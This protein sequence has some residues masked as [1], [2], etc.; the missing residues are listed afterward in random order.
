MTRHANRIPV[1]LRGLE[2]WVCWRYEQRRN[3]DGTSGKPT[4]VPYRAGGAGKAS[5]T[6]RATWS[7]YDAAVEAAASRGLDGIGFVFTDGDTFAGVDFD[8]CV[9]EGQVAAH[10]AVLI[11]QLD[12]Y[13]EISPSETG[14]HVIVKAAVNGG[15]KKIEGKDTPWGG[16]FENYDRGR[17][18]CFTGH[19]VDGTPTAVNPRQGE[20]DAIRHGLLSAE[21]SVIASN[22]A[23]SAVDGDILPQH[24]HPTLASFAGTMRRRGF[25][26]AAITA[27]L[28]V[29]NADRCKPPLE[30]REVR[31]VAK[32]IARYDP[33]EKAA[34]V[35]ALTGL[36]GLDTISKRIDT[37]RIY[38]RGSDAAAYIGLDDETR[39][40]LDPIGR[41]T[42]AAKLTAELALQAGASPPLK[43]GDVTRALVLLHDLGDHTSA[44]DINDRALDMATGYL[45]ATPIH[46]VRMD[47]TGERWQAFCELGRCDPTAEPGSAMDLARRSLVLEDPV[48]GVRYVRAEWFGGYVKRLTGAGEERAVLRTMTHLGW[49][50]PG[51]EGRIKATQPG[52][53]ATRQWAFFEVPKGWEQ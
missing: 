45:H 13:T 21:P 10:V 20:L 40:V 31:K 23:A 8:G 46:A 27:A 30:D 25:H 7:S 16:A 12:S 4:K 29:T 51:T 49:V 32:S 19:H 15:R 53:G 43:A 44:V 37:I 42:T 50:K 48:T 35:D 11:Q 38:G 26:E 24:R 52:F 6:E 17:F 33:A 41:F 14:V 18:F 34:T 3:T 5:S 1:E 47:D 2:Q 9:V 36:L 39:I 22:G 28:L